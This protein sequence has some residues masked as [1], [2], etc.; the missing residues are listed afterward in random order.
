MLLLHPLEGSYPGTQSPHQDTQ[1]WT[2]LQQVLPIYTRT[3]LTDTSFCLPMAMVVQP[4]LTST[5]SPDDHERKTASTERVASKSFV[6]SQGAR[7]PCRNFP[8]SPYAGLRNGFTTMHSVSNEF[9]AL[10]GVEGSQGCF[11]IFPKPSLIVYP[12]KR[13]LPIL[14]LRRHDGL[15]EHAM[16][17]SLCNPGLWN[18][19]LQRKDRLLLSRMTQGYDWS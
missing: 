4:Y 18:T 14:T 2:S 16:Q 7:P 10:L 13:L 5:R 3:Q 11:R 1:T 8:G 9:E 6:S 19:P 15:H 12:R 17:R